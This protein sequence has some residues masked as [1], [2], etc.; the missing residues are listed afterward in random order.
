MTGIASEPVG[1]PTAPVVP[2]GSSPKVAA[3]PTA[4][5]FALG[6]HMA[7]LFG[8]LPAETVT[9]P[10]DRLPTAA[11]LK[12]EDRMA[13]AFAELDSLIAKAGLGQLSA[14]SVSEAW[15]TGGL[16]DLQGALQTLNLGILEQLL[17]E[18]ERRAASY[19]LGRALSDTCWLPDKEGRV[20]VFLDQFSRQ[21]LGTLQ[22][23][24]GEMG[25]L[26]PQASAIAGRSLQ[27]W[28]DWADANAAAIQGNWDTSGPFIVAA[29]R[30]QSSVWHRLLSNEGDVSGQPPT[31]AWIRAGEAMLQSAHNLLWKILRHFW[32]VVLVILVAIGGLLYLAIAQTSGTTTVWTSLVTVVGGFGVSGAGLRAAGK[33]VATGVEQ[34][35][36]QA[37]SLDARAWAVTW[38]PALRQGPVLRH[39]LNQQ[40]VAPP[41]SGTR[42]AHHQAPSLPGRPPA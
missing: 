27:N 4:P 3:I 42:L 38:L 9:T 16:P 28:Q 39:R 37:A 15:A 17:H 8:P 41:A 2:N 19:Q 7:Q 22:T 34:S 13:L 20:D 1:A 6:W 30:T 32:L 26:A 12:V 21:R 29:L 40:G 25:A 18:D 24:L 23:W 10:D 31:A 5:S 33:R 35:A 11:E 36:W 14:T